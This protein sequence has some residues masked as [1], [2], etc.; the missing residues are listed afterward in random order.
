MNC[1][2]CGKT[3][4]KG[5]GIMFVKKD[6]TTFNFCSRKCEKNLLKLKRNPRNTKWTNEYHKIKKSTK[7]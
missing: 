3:I 6:G 7:K 1:S 2:F 4:K 5:T